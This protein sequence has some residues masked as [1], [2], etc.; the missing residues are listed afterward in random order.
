MSDTPQQGVAAI[1]RA[2]AASVSSEA[3]AGVPDPLPGDPRDG[4]RAGEWGQP[5]DMPPDCPVQVLG[6]GPGTR[7][8]VVDNN[9]Q[10]ESFDANRFSRG[11]VEALFGARLN[12]LIWAWPRYDKKGKLVGFRAEQVHQSF[13]GEAD[14]ITER[15]GL[16]DPVKRTRG[17]GAWF[18]SDRELIYHAGSYLWRNGKLQRAGTMI[19]GQFYEL[20]ARIPMPWQQPVEGFENPAIEIGRLLQTWSW[21]RPRADP[22]IVL[23]WI[24]AAM[25]SGVL[26]WRPSVFVV[27]D[28]AVGKSTLQNLIKMVIGAGGVKTADTSQAGIYQTLKM[29]ALPVQ[30][31]ELEASADNRKALQVVELARIA[32]SGDERIRGGQDHTSTTFTARSSFFFSAINPPPMTAA[33]WSRLAVLTLERLD[34][35]KAAAAPMLREH[36]LADAGR[37]ILRRLLDHWG[38]F[39]GLF[40]LYRAALQ[41]GGHDNRGCDTYGTFLAAAHVLLGDEGV[42]ALGLPIDTLDHWAD[43]LSRASLGEM[44]EQKEN[45][46]NCL[47]HLLDFKMTDRRAQREIVIG[48]LLDDLRSGVDRTFD[49]DKA[50]DLLALVG[51]GLKAT[52]PRHDQDWMS[53]GLL[54]A[55]PNR[56]EAV[57]GIF[58]GG[59]W[60][61]GPGGSGGWSSALRQGPPDVVVTD[62]GQNAMRINGN[63][64]RC[65][66]IDLDGFDALLKRETDAT[67]RGA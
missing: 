66:L 16:W 2:A 22:F 41:Q 25:M 40:K 21:K 42:D 46:R 52:R 15:F 19:D 12:Y 49:F 30:I 44:A 64:H 45:W 6:K 48:A 26:E 14:R 35:E 63:M 50:R 58:A 10:L 51:L 61:V 53:R 4:V 37:K 28:K 55:V 34:P 9:G 38:E 59:T 1:V 5:P 27:G 20:A 56:G 65:T 31:D 60:A 18:T 43:W 47:D 24:A 36:S 11:V 13:R 54:L 29:D 3:L 33:D 17:R 7:I 23:G 39:D 8:Y 67:E 62:K 32:A 57:G